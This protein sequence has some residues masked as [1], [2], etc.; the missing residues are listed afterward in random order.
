MS[1]KEESKNS[2]FYMSK[3]VALWHRRRTR[4]FKLGMRWKR[5]HFARS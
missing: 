3:K 4:Q 1:I 2:Q 5:G